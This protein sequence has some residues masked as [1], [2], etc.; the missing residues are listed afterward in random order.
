MSEVVLKMA[1][2]AAGVVLSVVAFNTPGSQIIL[3]A[4]GGALMGAPIG[5]TIAQWD[6]RR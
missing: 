2:F 4:V 1:A 5:V 6:E 3:A